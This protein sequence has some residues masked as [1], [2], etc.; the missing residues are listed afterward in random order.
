MHHLGS[1]QTSR[2]RREC[3]LS[4]A[5]LINLA[6]RELAAFARAVG[7]LFGAEQATLSAVDWI[8]ELESMDWPARPGVS[9]FRR[10]TIATSARLVQRLFMPPREDT[11]TVYLLS[12]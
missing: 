5:D 11:R 7:E 9:D 6:K 10:I 3:V 8:D 1:N 12:E 4:E 2:Q